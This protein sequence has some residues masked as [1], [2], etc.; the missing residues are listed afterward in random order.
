MEQAGHTTLQC[1]RFRICDHEC[2]EGDSSSKCVKLLPLQLFL[3]SEQQAD[4]YC[5]NTFSYGISCRES[6]IHNI[7]ISVSYPKRVSDHTILEPVE[8]FEPPTGC[9]QNNYSTPELHRLMLRP[10]EA[11]RQ[12]RPRRPC[13]LAFRSV[14]PRGA[15][16]PHGGQS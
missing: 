16:I 3:F 9:L 8:G 13:T 10:T 12:T 5:C 2:Q 15:L 14:W 4:T 7:H 11:R 1:H 6:P